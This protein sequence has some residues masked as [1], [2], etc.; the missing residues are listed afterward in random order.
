MLLYA[1]L[2]R[3]VGAATVGV[4]VSLMAAGLLACTADLG[5]NY[6]LVR[7][8]ALTQHDT[9]GPSAHET[10]ETLVWSVVLLAGAALVATHLAFPL[11]SAW[12]NL[13]PDVHVNAVRWLPFVLIGLWLNRIADALGGCLD[14]QQRFVE[15][16]IAGTAALLAG[17]V[18]SVVCVPLW[19]MDGLAAAF[20][21][22]NA[23]V[24]GANFTLLTAG[25]PGLRWL[26][27]RLRLD[28][29]RDAARYGLSIQALVLCYLVLESGTKLTL[30]RSGNLTAV[31]Y[32]DLSF[33]IAKGIRGLL[34]SALRVL[35]PR[36]APTGG[37]VHGSALRGSLYARSFDALLVVAL[38]IFVGLLAASHGIAW[39]MVGRADPVFIEALMFALLAWLAYSLT[40]P[41]LN[42]AMASGRMAWPLGAHLVT[43]ALS[44]VLVYSLGSLTSYRG[45]YA[46]V[47]FAMLVGC[48]ITLVGVHRNEHLPWR[49]LKPGM[50]VLVLLSG[51]LA[52]LLG[53]FATVL[54][55]WPHPILRW[56]AVAAGYLGFLAILWQHPS[57]RSL[58]G[59]RQ[60]A[61]QTPQTAP[62]HC[63]PARRK[64][65]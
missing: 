54:L 25:L 1:Y 14:G 34:A 4:W 50:T 2:I 59:L 64:C 13:A 60:A 32:F 36:L 3:R 20:V 46:I 23:L 48:V 28:V 30:A 39:L 10:V 63:Q 18:L 9:A 17:L 40:D 52:G 24:A 8:L 22:Q 6:A 26:R 16:S 37:L 38:P 44:A 19:G 56:C 31:S 65:P 7:R 51:V 27:P 41:A 12:L 55:P 35:V 21:V 29:L 11:W 42:L 61:D 33:R 47:M 5:L 53:V 62:Q 45:L 43:L 58:L 49:L 57:A 15:R